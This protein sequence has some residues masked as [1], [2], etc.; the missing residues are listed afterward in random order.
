MVETTALS[1]PESEARARAI[2]SYTERYRAPFSLRCGAL[3]I[4]YIVV[5]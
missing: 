3:L 5:I 1:Q 2:D 4:D